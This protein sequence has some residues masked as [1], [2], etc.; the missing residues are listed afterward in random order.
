MFQSE[1]DVHE[2]TLRYRVGAFERAKGCL[3]QWLALIPEVL[4]STFSSHCD[5]Y[6]YFSMYVFVKGVREFNAVHTEGM[7]E[8]FW[9]CLLQTLLLIGQGWVGGGILFAQ[10]LVF[11]CLFVYLKSNKVVVVLDAGS[12]LEN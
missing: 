1:W 11:V 3:L 6:Y 10:R 7:T 5:Y 2:L 12:R 8:I 4:F 9:V